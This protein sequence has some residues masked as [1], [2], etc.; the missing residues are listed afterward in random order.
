MTWHG[1]YVE[2]L[3]ESE[4]QKKGQWLAPDLLSSMLAGKGNSTVIDSV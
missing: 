4:T 3:P 2:V 1:G